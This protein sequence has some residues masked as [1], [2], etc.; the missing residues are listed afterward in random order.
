MVN[1]HWLVVWNMNFMDDFSIQLGMSSSQLTKSSFSE[2][3]LKP[4]TRIK[5]SMMFSDYIHPIAVLFSASSTA[6][7]LGMEPGMKSDRFRLLD[8]DETGNWGRLKAGEHRGRFREKNAVFFFPK[9]FY[10]NVDMNFWYFTYWFQPSLWHWHSWKVGGYWVQHFRRRRPQSG[11]GGLN[12]R[13]SG[14]LGDVAA[15]RSGRVDPVAW[16]VDGGWRVPVLRF[17][18]PI[19]GPYVWLKKWE[20]NMFFLSF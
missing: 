5:I 12:L 10:R 20:K 17:G 18:G 3:R 2:G 13:R 9:S 14:R 4:P 16:R 8:F 15:P 11:A 6:T 7:R 1:N 19:D